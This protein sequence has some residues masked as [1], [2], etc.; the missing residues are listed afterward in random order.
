MKPEDPSLSYGTGSI[1]EGEEDV[2]HA[3]EN[4]GR[5]LRLWRRRSLYSMA[6]LILS[7]AFVI[8]FSKGHFLHAHAEPFGRLLV[9][10][11]MA[12]LIVFVYCTGLLW[13]A[14]R[15]LRDLEQGRT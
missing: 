2:A 9:Y 11:S 13:G 15:S 5:R 10:L 8:P 6:A 12:L 3:R 1:P 14:R 7:C 4:A